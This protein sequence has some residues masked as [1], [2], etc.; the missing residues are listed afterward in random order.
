MRYPADVCPFAALPV[1]PEVGDWADLAS[2]A[3]PGAVVAFAA[4][5]IEPPEDWRVVARIPGVQ[6]VDD[7]VAAVPAEGAVRLGPADAAEML[8]LVERTKPGP[9]AL[10]TFEMG[11]YLGIRREGELIASCRPAR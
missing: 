7:G 9:F 4:V 8:S 6:L 2:L 11:T 1:R 10:R 3:G 5:D